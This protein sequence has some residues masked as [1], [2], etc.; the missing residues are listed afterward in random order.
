[1]TILNTFPVY[2]TVTEFVICAAYKLFIF[3]IADI[4]NSDV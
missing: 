3:A 1:M 4:D 2:C